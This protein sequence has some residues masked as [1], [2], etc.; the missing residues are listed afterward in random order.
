[1]Q[2]QDLPLCPFE[3]TDCHAYRNRYCR[4]LIDVKFPK[5]KDCVFYKTKEQN[6]AE[7]A[8]VIEKLK[9]EKKGSLLEHYRRKK[10]E[11]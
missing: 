5:G 1:M 2:N 4:A 8:A 11:C 3:H 10:Y 9:A 7:D 6:D